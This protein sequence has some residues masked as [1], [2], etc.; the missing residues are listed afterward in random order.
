MMR[1]IDPIIIINKNIEKFTMK[2]DPHL[3]KIAIVHDWLPLIGGAEKVLKEILKVYPQADVYTLFNFLDE[4]QL[5]GLGIKNIT[6]SYL[7]KLPY[8]KKYY[9]H[10]LPFCPQ[11]I[12]D[13]DL[14][15]YDLVISSSYAVAKGVITGGHQVHVSYIHSPAR[16]A[17][18]LTH[19]Y[20]K[21]GGLNTGIKGLLVKYLLSRFRIWDY[22]T[23]NSV[24]Y[25]MANSDF[26]KKR[27]WKIYRRDAVVVYPP[28]DITGFEYKKDKEDFYLAA[29]RLVPYKRLDI[30]VEAFTN[31]PNKR[32]VVIGDGPEL[33]NIK[34]LANGHPN[35]EIL[36]F[37]ETAALM[38]FMQRAKAFVF[39]AQEDFGIIPLEAQA[40][41]T[42]VIAYGAGGALETVVNYYEHPETAT[43]IFF[44]NQS[45][46]SIKLAVT[47]FE[48][49][50]NNITSEN[51]RKNAE[52]FSADVFRDKFV[53]NIQLAIR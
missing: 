8:V 51:C 46:E 30:I 29:S 48:K 37:L 4:K 52:R 31:M 32:L 11:A 28:V 15:D 42:P 22:R 14:H 13:F 6:T 50:S 1:S 20:L 7:N 16:Y 44:E 21:R 26:I 40:C 35:I 38:D 9:R 43:G 33:E 36:G 19:S 10:L 47:N 18:D 39:A 34:R 41:G 24:D 2:K 23:A 53:N 25:Y 27:I 45:A 5:L 3:M 49:I 17:W 12:E